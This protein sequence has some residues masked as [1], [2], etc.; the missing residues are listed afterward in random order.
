MKIRG[1]Y[2]VKIRYRYEIMDDWQ[3]E[4]YYVEAKG[5]SD[6]HAQAAHDFYLKNKDL[7]LDYFRGDDEVEAFVA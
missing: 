4:V 5:P 1:I 7:G 6:A 3:E 2:K